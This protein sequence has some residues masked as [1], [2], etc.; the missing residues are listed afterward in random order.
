MAENER[1]GPSPRRSRGRSLWPDGLSLVVICALV[2]LYYYPEG[3][4]LESLYVRFAETFERSAHLLNPDYDG[5]FY[6]R[7]AEEYFPFLTL[8]SR[9]ALMLFPNDP[10]RAVLALHLTIAGAS[11]ITT[12]LLLRRFLPTVSA[13]LVTGFC[14]CGRVLLPPARTWGFTHFQLLIPIS[15]AFVCALPHLWDRSGL[16]GRKVLWILLA[17][18]CLA[19]IYALGA[20]ETFYAAFCLGVGLATLGCHWL[21]RSLRARRPAPGP[22][23]PFVLALLGSIPLGMA[24]MAW[25]Y[26][27]MPQRSNP[28]DFRS[29]I[30][31]REWLAKAVDEAKQET[32]T[33]LDFKLKVLRGTFIEG[34]YLTQYGRTHREMF[35]YPGAGFNGIVPL[36]MLP[37]LAIG[38]A[39]G[40][41][42]AFRW[43]MGKQTNETPKQTFFAIF[44]ALLVSLFVIMVVTSSNPK[45]TRYTYSILAVY[46]LTAWGYEALIRWIHRRWFRPRTDGAAEWG[47][48]SSTGLKAAC[49]VLVPLVLL[50]GARLL[51][52]HRDLG[53]HLRQWA[54]RIHTVTLKPDIER[55]LQGER[56]VV[57]LRKK[58][59]RRQTH[60]GYTR[61]GTRW[62][63]PAIGLK[64]RYRRPPNLIVIG[65]TPTADDDRNE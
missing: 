57:D 9:W 56:I 51:K 25:V 13:L 48:T 49:I 30:T 59:P 21:I 44:I 65:E 10:G 28:G 63:D 14:L 60:H 11:G 40:G 47:P 29:L 62:T 2:Y 34:R 16:N 4:P 5:W 12:F 3:D 35:L 46:V 58:R 64:L 61:L 31:Y 54:D 55:L 32:E 38:L 53:P 43:A 19:W 39:L 15:L 20:H 42:A 26:F 6:R 8:C 37:G 36:F 45:P 22:P 33:S 7:R 52:N 41:R 23:L 18:A 27:A 1:P 24:F 50:A 17:A